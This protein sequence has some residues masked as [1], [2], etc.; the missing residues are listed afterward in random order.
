MANGR[1]QRITPQ[2]RMMQEVLDKPDFH[3]TAAELYEVLRQRLPRISLGTVYRNLDLLVKNGLIN[4]LDTGSSESRFDGNTKKHHHIRCVACR[5]ID[6][7]N[8]L[9]PQQAD[10]QIDEIRGYRIYDHH[11]EFV[12]ICPS[13]RKRHDTGEEKLQ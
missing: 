7:I 5:R 9:P 8:E 13:C 4:K 11:Y 3:P 12:G 1:I 6:D 10:L 2:R